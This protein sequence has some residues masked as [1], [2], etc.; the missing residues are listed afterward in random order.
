MAAKFQSLVFEIFDLELDAQYGDG[1]GTSRVHTKSHNYRSPNRI[2]VETD[3]SLKALAGLTV[4]HTSL[5]RR[6]L[7]QLDQLKSARP[8]AGRVGV[9]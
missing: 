3:R 4:W 6:Q 5:P 8:D 2:A 9:S 1:C 7:V